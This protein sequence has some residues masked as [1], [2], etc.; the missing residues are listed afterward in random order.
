MYRTLLYPVDGSEL[1]RAA[2][3]HVSEFARAAGATVIVVQAVEIVTEA[4]AMT[5]PERRVEAEAFVDAAKGVES[6]D[7]ALAGARDIIAEIINEDTQA[8]A[9]VRS[10]FARQGIIY[11]KVA[12]GKETEG[13]KYKD[14]AA[15]IQ[16]HLKI[17]G[18]KNQ[19]F[20]DEAVLAIHQGSGGLLR[21][22]NLLAKGALVAAAN[23]KCQIVSPEHVR[24]ASTEIM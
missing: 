16:H 20:A 19:L 9:I 10:L 12:K 18:G 24:M 2:L 7:E 8:R 4:D 17:A 14:M 15:Y 11:A 5:V 22:A 23:E 3:A 21:R 13:L 1:S 6:A